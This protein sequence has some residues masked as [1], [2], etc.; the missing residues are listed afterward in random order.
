MWSVIYSEILFKDWYQN[1]IGQLKFN[2]ASINL[3][4]ILVLIDHRHKSNQAYKQQ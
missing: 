3:D 1:C 4:S 2:V